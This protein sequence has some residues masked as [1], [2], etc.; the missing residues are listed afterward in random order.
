MAS[1]NYQQLRADATDSLAGCGKAATMLVLLHAGVS[2]GIN[3]VITAI[4]YVLDLGIAQTGG[5][6]GMDVRTTLETIQTLLTY[7]QTLALPFWEMGYVF[8]VLRLS[9]REQA[10]KRDLLAGFRWFGP[11][12][13]GRILTGI[14]YFVLMMVGAQAGSLLF[15]LTPAAKEMLSFDMAALEE[16]LLALME[17]E[18]YM[19]AMMPAMPFVLIGMLL[20]VIPVY[21]RLR[22]MDYVLMDE[23]QFGALY[24]LLKSIHMTRRQCW[25]LFKLDLRFWWFYLLQLLTLALWYG[26]IWLPMLGVDLGMSAEGAMYLFYGLALLAELALYVWKRNQVCVTYAMVYDELSQ[27]EV[28]APKPEPQPKNMPWSY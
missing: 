6:G 25:A 20:P 4:N 23:P 22:M 12:L 26:D 16:D 21:Y 8:V 28:P 10:E 5:L 3:L 24:A 2:L 1:F 27:Q 14:I 15:M 11:V 19:Q 18:A 17:N 7:V 13:R 9:R